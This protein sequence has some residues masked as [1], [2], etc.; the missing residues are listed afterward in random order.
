M[1]DGYLGLYWEEKDGGEMK[2]M[3]GEGG[4]GEKEY[5]GGMEWVEG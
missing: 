5:G 3:W 4:Y 2:G 1:G